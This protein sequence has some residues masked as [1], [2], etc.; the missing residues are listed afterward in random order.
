MITIV[1]PE[2]WPRV[3]FFWVP[4]FIRNIMAKGWKTATFYEALSHMMVSSA[5]SIECHEFSLL[6]T[7]LVPSG[8]LGSQ[9]SAGGVTSSSTMASGKRLRTCEAT[10][11]PARG[12]YQR[13]QVWFHP[14]LRNKNKP[15]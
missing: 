13:A 9:G 10:P 2:V 5:I 6:F 12:I 14:V 7:Q 15:N 4:S 3:L 8:F 11:P 1:L